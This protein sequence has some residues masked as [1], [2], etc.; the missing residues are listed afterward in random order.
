MSLVR[1]ERDNEVQM[2][3]NVFLVSPVCSTLVRLIIIP[4]VSSGREPPFGIGKI[5]QIVQIP[6]LTKNHN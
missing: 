2:L 6:K 3:T 1:N 5:V 4:E